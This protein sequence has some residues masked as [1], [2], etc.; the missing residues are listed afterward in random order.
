MFFFVSSG[1]AIVSSPHHSTTGDYVGDSLVLGAMRHLFCQKKT[2]RGW[3]EPNISE[4]LISQPADIQ[5]LMT[6]IFLDLAAAGYLDTAST[7]Q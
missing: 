4:H 7:Y 6:I 2:Y 5:K 3:Q 1:G